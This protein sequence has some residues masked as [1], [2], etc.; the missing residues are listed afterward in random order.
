MSSTKSGK[1]QRV[2][3]PTEER[4]KHSFGYPQLDSDSLFSFIRFL[5][6]LFSLKYYYLILVEGAAVCAPL[7]KIDIPKN[8]TSFSENLWRKK[9]R[10]RSILA[11]PGKIFVLCGITCKCNLTNTYISQ[12][13]LTKFNI[14][15]TNPCH[16]SLTLALS[17][18][19]L[20][21]IQILIARLLFSK[22]TKFRDH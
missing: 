12:P 14:P 16:G 2:Q 18:A 15:C 19:T 10:H 17:E 13:Y 20:T 3:G 7:K 8:A 11:G 1:F 9:V 6:S 21:L 5:N 22:V 4:F